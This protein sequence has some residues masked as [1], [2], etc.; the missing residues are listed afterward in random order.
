MSIE[1]KY[2]VGVIP[3]RLNSKRLPQKLLQNLCGKPILQWTFER[4]KS[5]KFLDKILIA[6][7]SELIAELVNSF[8]GESVITSSEIKCGT[9]RVYAALKKLSLRPH[10]VINIQGDEPFITG[11]IIDALVKTFLDE[12]VY[13]STL[14]S[15]ITDTNELF[16][17]SVVKVVLDKSNFALY[18]SRSPIP[19][20]RDFSENEWLR[21]GRFY[22][23]VGIYG[24]TFDFLEKYVHT[25]ESSLEHQERL[26]QLRILEN[27][28]KIKCVEIEEELLSIDTF[29]DLEKAKIIFPRILSNE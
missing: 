29:E 17:P 10:I 13:A 6:T 4:S 12:T 7:D 9:D 16:N 15:K 8:G 25:P 21:F 28:Y 3:A 19:Y 2:V 23:H 27:G 22:K 14:I 20:Q 26:E 11:K 5:S 18:F 1:G 24:F